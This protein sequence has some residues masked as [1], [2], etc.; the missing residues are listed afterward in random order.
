MLDMLAARVDGDHLQTAAI[1]D[2]QLHVL[3]PGHRS[4]RLRRSRA[5]AT[6]P[7]PARQAEIDGDP[8]GSARSTTCAP[9]RRERRR[10]RCTS[11]ASRRPAGQRPARGRASALS[12][13]SGRAI[14]RT[15]SGLTVV[16]VL[17]E[18]SAGLEEEGCAAAAGPGQR[19]RST[20]G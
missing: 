10:T 15:L 18:I 4:Q 20:S 7:T 16:D 19:H 1:F 9:T 13:A 2:E 3:S 11:S 6:R 12:P 14:W 17:R 8:A 5:R